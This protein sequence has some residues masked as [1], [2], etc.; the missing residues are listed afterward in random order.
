MYLAA[1]AV[2]VVVVIIVVEGMRESK[3]VVCFVGE[4]VTM[5]LVLDMVLVVLNVGANPVPTNVFLLRVAR[6]VGQDP[7]PLIIQ[8]VRLGEVNDIKSY[9]VALFCVADSEEVPLGVPICVNIVLEDQVVLVLA[10]LDCN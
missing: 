9:F 7:H 6:G 1:G 3:C 5:H 8:T 2:V 10:D 4:T